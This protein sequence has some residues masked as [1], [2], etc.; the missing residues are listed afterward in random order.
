M[1]ELRTFYAEHVERLAQLYAGGVATARQLRDAA[2]SYTS[3][4]AGA[5]IQP[6]DPLGDLDLYPETKEQ[7]AV[8]LAHARRA[9]AAWPRAAAEVEAIVSDC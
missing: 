1:Q 4:C 3:R 6:A 7:I 2:D 8:A 5:G 9:V